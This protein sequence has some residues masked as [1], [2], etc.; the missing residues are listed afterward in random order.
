MGQRR[1]RRQHAGKGD[2]EEEGEGAVCIPPKVWMLTIH[3]NT[4]KLLQMMGIDLTDDKLYVHY[5]KLA[6]EDAYRYRNMAL[7]YPEL[8]KLISRYKRAIYGTT[9][10][11]LHGIMP[12][13]DGDGSHY[14]EWVRVHK[15]KCPK[16]SSSTKIAGSW[17]CEDVIHQCGLMYFVVV[18]TQLIKKYRAKLAVLTSHGTPASVV[19]V[20][21]QHGGSVAAAAAHLYIIV[22]LLGTFVCFAGTLTVREIWKDTMKWSR[23]NSMWCLLV[24]VAL[25]FALYAIV[26]GSLGCDTSMFSSSSVGPA[27][28]ITVVQDRGLFGTETQVEY[29]GVPI[30]TQYQSNFT[31]SGPTPHRGLPPL[32]APVQPPPRP[33]TIPYPSPLPPVRTHR[34]AAGSPSTVPTSTDEVRRLMLQHES[35]NGH[36]ARDEGSVSQRVAHFFSMESVYEF[37]H[38]LLLYGI[39]HYDMREMTRLVSDSRFPRW[40]LFGYIL[41]SH[42]MCTPLSKLDKVAQLTDLIDL[43]ASWRDSSIRTRSQVL[44]NEDAS[45]RARREKREDKE[46]AKASRSVAKAANLPPPPPPT[47]PPDREEQEKSRV[48]IH[49]H[50]IRRLTDLRHRQIQFDD[51]KAQRTES[52]GGHRSRG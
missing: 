37:I 39:Q 2:G 45:T 1:H 36:D 23:W 22:S 34:Q 20:V 12:T 48:Y 47:G 29:D 4:T 27:P 14:D 8:G 25:L 17:H 13:V 3:S 35:D 9:G 46:R 51:A 31:V 43:V 38:F 7:F 15:H 10:P 28:S 26:A 49:T 11:D 5:T 6:T 44:A 19:S 42:K 18:T 21:G 52:R 50:I 32:R 30:S 41:F 40:R 24:P 16:V 33:A